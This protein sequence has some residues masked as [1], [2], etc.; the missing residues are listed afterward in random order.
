MAG[1]LVGAGGPGGRA[2]IAPGA[3]VL[4]IRVAGW[5]R[6]RT[7][8][9][10]VYAR[11]D[12]LIA[13]LERAVDPN[14]DGDAHDAA[15]IALVGVGRAVRGLRRLARGAGGRRARSSS[16]RSSSRRPGTTAPPAPATAASPA[17]A[18][19][20]PR[21]PS[22]AADL[23]RAPRRC[24]VAVRAGLDVVL[25]RP[26]PLAGAVVSAQPGRSSSRRPRRGGGGPSALDRLLRRRGR[27]LVAGRAALVHARR[28]PAARDR[29]RGA[30]GRGGGRRLRA[31]LPAGGL[32]VD[33]SVDVPVVSV[34]RARSQAARSPRSRGA[35]ARRSRSA[36]PSAVRNG[37]DG[38]IAPF[39]SRGLAFDGRVKPDL[40]AP[41]VALRDLRA[42]RERR[43]RAEL[44][45]GQRLERRRRRSSR[46]PRRCSPR[47][48]RTCARLDLRSLLAGDGAPIRGAS[49]HGAGRRPRR[50][51]RRRGRRD[52][53][54]TRSTLALRPRA[55][56]R[57][58]R[59]AAARRS[60][61]SR[62]GRCSSACAA[63]G[64]G[65]LV[66]ASEPRWVRL[67]PGGTRRSTCA[68]G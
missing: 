2:G 10:A 5:Q 1:I 16:T 58:A 64:S 17:P 29:V 13:G 24:R 18:A 66:I 25:D 12:Q 19:R 23:R 22:G 30:G 47:P 37:S 46:A 11:T 33:E 54:P 4:P 62:P 14:L 6:D 50:P 41:G 21:S 56:R 28:R 7:G 57:L 38:G 34:P 15:R 36:A 55:G 27:S 53:A 39:S 3:S 26:L 40:A 49:R 65:G 60:A 42:G 52:R 63:A 45:H 31:R 35:S 59:R 67:K 44:R 9:W 20:R 61:T 43:R 8:G 48:G 51:R 68:R 32:G